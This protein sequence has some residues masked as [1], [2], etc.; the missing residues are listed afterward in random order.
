[1]NFLTPKLLGKFWSIHIS[2]QFTAYTL[3]LIK[4]ILFPIVMCSHFSTG[5]FLRRFKTFSRSLMW[6]RIN[7]SSSIDPPHSKSK[8]WTYFSYRSRWRFTLF[9]FLNLS[10]HISPGIYT[11]VSKA[12][13][14]LFQLSYHTIWW[15]YL[16][17]G[18]CFGCADICQPSRP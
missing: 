2:Q 8:I 13:K 10:L 9:V 3:V 5:W 15:A 12:L 4:R 14:V 6:L 16:N 11:D 1:M 17:I 18:L 7:S